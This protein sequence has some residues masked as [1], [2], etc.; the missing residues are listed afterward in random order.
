MPSLKFYSLMFGFVLLSQIICLPSMVMSQTQP[1]PAAGFPLLID[2]SGLSNPLEG[3]TLADLNRDKQLEI[4]VASGNKVFVFRNNGS[5]FPGWPQTTTYAT[6]NSPAVGDL[7]NDGV[8][9]IVTCDRTGF[10]RKSFLYAWKATGQLLP[11]FPKQFG[12]IS[13]AI[14]LY[15]LDDNGTLEILAGVERQ[16]YAFNHDGSTL[17]GWPKNLAP[18]YP[19]SKA[20]VADINADGEPEIIVAAEFIA[21]INQE[22]NL[23]QLYAW[24]KNGELLSGWPIKT[25][26]GFVFAGFCNPALAD[27]DHDGFMEIAVATFSDRRSPSGGFAALYRHDGIMMPGWPIFTAGLD[28]LNDLNAA[29]AIG[30]I[31]GDGELE[32]I[33][34]DQFD[35]IIALNGDGSLATGWPAVLKQVDSTLVFRSTYMN[36]AIGDVD[37]DGESEIFINNNQADI[38]GGSWLGRIYA[39]N[40]D[41]TNLSWSPL[42]PRQFASLNTVAMGDLEGDGSVELVTVSSDASDKETWLTVWEIPGVPY[43]EER[44]PWPMYGH[45]RWHT[46]Q[47]GFKPTD[48]P[49]VGV[50]E[51]EARNQLPTAFLLHQNYPNPFYG[52]SSL[53]RGSRNRTEISYQLPVTSHVELRVLNLLGAEVRRL[54][55]ATQVA[56]TYKTFWEGR[57]ESGKLLPA[58]I[59]F[60]RM[61]A[62]PQSRGGEIFFSIKK[63]TKLD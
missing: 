45:D 15:D 1:T 8:L 40:H 12:L 17:P 44:F 30:D 11:G 41:A 34:A 22:E 48:E 21:A 47:Y 6:V 50:K 24:N 27:I 2:S 14:T 7:D 57:D 37:G 25:P 36:P 29:P 3:P 38:V 55:E 4:V 49:T 54:V 62:T 10:S 43:V 28:S 46:S 58:G 18:F 16:F 13:M 31:D 20:S 59:Y 39:I 26:A 9:D 52:A 35:H 53:L 56:G 63:L 42:R 23:G 32:L 33:F 61:E 51:N 60:Y 5:L 19:N